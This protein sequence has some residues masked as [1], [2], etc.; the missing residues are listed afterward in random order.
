MDE[1]KIWEQFYSHK[2]EE[3]DILL[4]LVVMPKFGHLIIEEQLCSATK[5]IR[6]PLICLNTDHI[7]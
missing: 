3:S 5:L 6:K 4:V 2:K 1:E 7:K